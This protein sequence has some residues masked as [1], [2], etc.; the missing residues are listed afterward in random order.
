MYNWFTLLYT[1]NE[2]NTVHM[3]IKIKKKKLFKG[4]PAKIRDSFPLTESTGWKWLQGACKWRDQLRPPYSTGAKDQQHSFL[5]AG[6]AVR[7]SMLALDVKSHW[8]LGTHCEWLPCCPGGPAGT[9]GILWP[10]RPTAIVIFAKLFFQLIWPCIV[11][12]ESITTL[13]CEVAGKSVTSHLEQKEGG[14]CWGPWAP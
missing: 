8:R 7:S 13:D 1:W 2:H 6:E 5:G 3:P 9:M 10:L 12:P 14:F 11:Q 4:F